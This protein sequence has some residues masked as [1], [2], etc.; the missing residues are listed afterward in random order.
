MSLLDNNQAEK[1]FTL[2]VLS[3]VIVIPDRTVGKFSKM[4]YLLH[5]PEQAVGRSILA[6]K[7]RKI[8]DRF[9]GADRL[10]ASVHLHTISIK[11]NKYPEQHFKTGDGSAQLRL[12]AFG[13][14]ARFTA[15]FLQIQDRSDLFGTLL[16]PVYRHN[17]FFMSL[18]I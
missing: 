9:D 15:F 8:V 3:P 13:T 4:E 12:V 14:R 16:K 6:T 11:D 2:F 10:V 18:K 17:F 5:Q 1:K 7:L